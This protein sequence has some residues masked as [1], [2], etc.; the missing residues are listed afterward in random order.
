MKKREKI[1]IGIPCYQNVAAQTLED[2]MRFAYHM[3]RRMPEYDFYLGVKTK[4]EQFRARNAIV[5]YARDIGSDWLLMI[6]DDHIIN[7]EEDS[8]KPGKGADCYGFL[9]KLLDHD[10]DIVG[11]TYYQ[12]G[13]QAKPVVMDKMGAGFKFMNDSDLTGGLQEVAVQ[14]GG[15]ILIK[16]HIFD[17]LKQPWFEPEH[18]YGTDI[19]LCKAAKEAG[20]KVYTDSSLELGHVYEQ[21]VVISSKNKN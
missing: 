14:G 2:Y 19:Q 18:T 13:G 15:C 12:R 17:K 10:V 20:F 16:M 9:Q 21:R 11:P 7:Y 1:F 4:T 6:D 8:G 3:G 5:Q